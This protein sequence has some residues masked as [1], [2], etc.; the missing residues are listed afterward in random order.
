MDEQQAAIAAG[1]AKLR[2]VYYERLPLEIAELAELATR[3]IGNTDT[4]QCLEALHQRLH[5]L[6]GSGGTFGI[7]ELSRQALAL[8]NIVQ[9]WLTNDFSAVDEAKRRRFAS[10]VAALPA[11]PNRSD[12][13]C[14][15]IRMDSNAH[16]ASVCDERRTL[17]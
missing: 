9:A 11:L 13:S 10:A 17:V 7:G 8:E 15:A 5:K 1:L 12:L 4:R 3:L 6:A 14:C 16:P 2:D